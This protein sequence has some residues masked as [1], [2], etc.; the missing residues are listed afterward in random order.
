M[1][2]AF[3]PTRSTSRPSRRQ[4]A[5]RQRSHLQPVNSSMARP[6]LTVVPAAPNDRVRQ[7]PTRR[8]LPMWLR[9]LIQLQRGS[10]VVTFIL[11]TAA[12]VLYGST[13]YMQQHWSKEYRKLKTMQRSERQMVTAKELM[14]NQLIQQAEQPGS[15]LVPRTTDHTIFLEPAPDRV[16][17]A[18][19]P[20]LAKPDSAPNAS[21]PLGY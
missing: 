12:L 3:K 10:L 20:T 1:A 15:G 6:P 7:L 2:T 4:Q 18:A 11:V 8:S 14:K 13:I 19:D 21:A 5:A 17:V 9:L 16:P